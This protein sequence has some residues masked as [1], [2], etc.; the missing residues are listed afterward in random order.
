MT[1]EQTGAIEK[2]L[3]SREEIH[4]REALSRL[5][6]DLPEKLSQAFEVK[7]AKA[8]LRLSQPHVAAGD[9]YLWRELDP[10]TSIDSNFW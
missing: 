8:R 7:T 4:G 10:A 2:G 6:A 1:R 5:Q 9:Q 3:D